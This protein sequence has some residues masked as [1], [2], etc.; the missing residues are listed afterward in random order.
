MKDQVRTSSICRSLGSAFVLGQVSRMSG[1]MISATL[2]RVWVQRVVYP[3][4]SLAS[5]LDIGR[6][7][8]P[9]G[10]PIWL[11]IP[12]DRQGSKFQRRLRL[13]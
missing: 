8:P 3:C 13:P 5:C 2:M 10:M 12:S 6:L 4:S 9:I 7:R 1:F 11:R